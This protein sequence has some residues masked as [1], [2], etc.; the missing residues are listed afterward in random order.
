MNQ[1]SSVRQ[2]VRRLTTL[3]P[4][5]LISILH[6]KRQLQKWRVQ[7]PGA[8]FANFY[9][10][11]IARKL[12]QGRGH[13]TLGARGWLSGNN[14]SVEWDREL[15][16]RRGLQ[17]WDN[18]V[19]LG[20]KPHMR[21]VDYGC[22]SLRLGQHAMRYL[23]AGNYYGIDVTDSFIAT[24][25]G[26]VDPELLRSKAPHLATISGEVLRDIRAWE[27]DFIFSNAV[28]QHVPPEE[29]SLFFERLESMMAPHTKAFMLYIT[30]EKVERFDSMSWSYPADYIRTA[31]RSAAPSLKIGERSAH[32]SKRGDGRRREVLLLEG[33][34]VRFDR[35][36]RPAARI[37]RS[38]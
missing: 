8:P 2:F 15:F 10:E 22:G 14:S 38:A 31:A 27:P 18:I 19:A 17:R 26:L 3:P 33:A 9:A 13:T 35:A 28:L 21:C 1:F 23:D 7:H 25:L 11:R 36:E 32:H 20:L 37:R 29:L 16:A 4:V 34:G 12:R 5:R 30:G 6:S 24:G